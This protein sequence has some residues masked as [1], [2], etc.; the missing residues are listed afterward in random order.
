MGNTDKDGLQSDLLFNAVDQVLVKGDLDKGA[1]IGF[2]SAKT[3][4]ILV[5]GNQFA[6]S[7]TSPATTYKNVEGAFINNN[8]NSLVSAPSSIDATIIWSGAVVKETSGSTGTGAFVKYYDSLNAALDGVTSGN[9]LEILKSHALTAAGTLAAGKTCYIRNVVNPINDT[10]NPFIDDDGNIAYAS[11]K[12]PV[13]YFSKNV[14]DTITDYRLTI[15]GT[16]SLEGVK[17]SGHSWTGTETDESAPRNRATSGILVS[18]TGIMTIKDGSAG[19]L[20]DGTA[21]DACATEITDFVNTTPGDSN[22][23]GGGFLMINGEVTMEGGTVSGCNATSNNWKGGGSVAKISG[24]SDAALAK[25][26][27][28]G[29]NYYKQCNNCIRIFG[30]L[31]FAGSIRAF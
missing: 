22:Y 21:R 4:T 23:V 27:L 1:K 8:D 2:Y 10:E 28:K 7:D 31:F 24:T 9:T 19:E 30:M 15:N 5:S 20:P 12:E 25:F 17:F 29:R 18:A 3:A 14:S 16:V 13:V 6:T 26:Y 11:G